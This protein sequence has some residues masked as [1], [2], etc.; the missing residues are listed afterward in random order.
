MGEIQ[1]KTKEKT[2]EYIERDSDGET[3][4]IGTYSK[5]DD[6]DPI[7]L[8]TSNPKFQS[9]FSQLS[10]GK[11]YQLTYDETMELVDID[12]PNI[13]YTCGVIDSIGDIINGRYEITI[14]DFDKKHILTVSEQ[15]K[16]T[17]RLGD[18]YSIQYVKWYGRRYYRIIKLDNC[19]H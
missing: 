12:P 7:T 10:A 3:Y 8:S 17:I 19:G 11:T 13:Y 14:R 5:S 1:T 2:I 15:R 16:N 6:I 9:L 4:Y 18:V